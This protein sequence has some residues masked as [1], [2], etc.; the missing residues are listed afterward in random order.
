MPGV[1]GTWAG[2]ELESEVKGGH[3]GTVGGR[4]LFSC[5]PG[6]GVMVPMTHLIADPR[7]ALRQATMCLSYG[8]ATHRV[9]LGASL[10][11]WLTGRV[12]RMVTTSPRCRQHLRWK[13]S[14]Q[15]PAQLTSSPAEQTRWGS[16]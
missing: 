7:F 10:T 13:K 14:C 6:K 1:A 12:N 11:V 16:K 4:R 8:V 9:P 3:G 2:V 15:N 5:P